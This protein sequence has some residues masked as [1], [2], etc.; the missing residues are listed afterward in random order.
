MNERAKRA[1]STEQAMRDDPAYRRWREERVTRV[2]AAF[3]RRLRD[4]LTEREMEEVVRR[5]GRATSPHT[6]ASHDFVDANMVMDAAMREVCGEDLVGDA[7]S[8][9]AAEL[10]N[11]AWAAAKAADFRPERLRVDDAS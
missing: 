5:N 10:W 9:W 7:A 3:A 6:C 4:R 8:E 1:G 11:A 2:A